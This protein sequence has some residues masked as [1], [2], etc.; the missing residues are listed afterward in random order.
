MGRRA[1]VG[2]GLAGAAVVA[3]AG[4]LAFHRPAPTPIEVKTRFKAALDATGEWRAIDWKRCDPPHAYAVA[5]THKD[6]TRFELEQDKTFQGL[7][8][9]TAHPP[10]APGVSFWV[11]RFDGRTVKVRKDVAVP[12]PAEGEPYFR[13]P[14]VTEAERDRMAA[15]SA[16]LMDALV[17]ATR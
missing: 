1:W 11:T 12:H 10:A 2:V 7:P 13:H 17:A 9:V 15:A 4:V 6:G 8:T 5:V 3:V 14:D 16:D